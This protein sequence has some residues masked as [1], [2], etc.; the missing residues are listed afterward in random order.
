MGH[1][2][3]RAERRN[4][5]IRYIEKRKRTI[6]QTW[7][8]WKFGTEVPQIHGSW[9]AMRQYMYYL[10][11][12]EMSEED[13]RIAEVIAKLEG[14]LTAEPE[15][16]PTI[17]GKYAKYNLSCNCVQCR[18]DDTYNRLKEKRV[19][20]DVLREELLSTADPSEHL[21]VDKTI[22]ALDGGWAKILEIDT[23]KEYW[24]HKQNQHLC[25]SLVLVLGDLSSLCWVESLWV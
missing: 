14:K 19:V 16:K 11:W 4:T 23:R 10:S 2:K 17:W 6:K 24:M 7:H 1:P 21:K 20:R 12:Q 25:N 8:L 22:E 5:R 9:I 3:T 13:K 15:Y 18:Y